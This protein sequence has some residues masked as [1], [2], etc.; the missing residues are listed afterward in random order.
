METDAAMSHS[1]VFELPGLAEADSL[2][3]GVGVSAMDSVTTCGDR[4]LV[5]V[6]LPPEAPHLALI[7][8][9]AE[10]WLAA[11]GMRGIWFQLDGRYYLLRPEHDLV[12][13]IEAAAVAA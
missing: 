13:A 7:L 2:S 12:P 11:A 3:L 6:M 4:W 5:E 8:R 10:A 1:V 9:R